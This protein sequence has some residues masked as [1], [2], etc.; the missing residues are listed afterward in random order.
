MVVI[1]QSRPRSLAIAIATSASWPGRCLSRS[2]STVSTLFFFMDGPGLGSARHQDA[3]PA[4]GRHV[5]GLP[6]R[7]GL[8][9]PVAARP[10]LDPAQAVPGANLPLDAESG[11]GHDLE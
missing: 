1:S 3:R 11:H 7:Q 5:T 4:P 8:A 6:D 2:W 9:A 10:A